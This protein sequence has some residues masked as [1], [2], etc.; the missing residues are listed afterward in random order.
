MSLASKITLGAAIVFTTSIVTYVHTKQNQ[1]RVSLR[2]GVINDMQRQ[3]MK[4]RQNL[5][6]YQ[7]QRD[8]DRILRAEREK[9]RQESEKA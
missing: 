1:D 4:K 3:E 2:Q 6:Q 7:D 5:K 9:Q 8:I